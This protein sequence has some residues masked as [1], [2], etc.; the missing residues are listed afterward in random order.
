MQPHEATAGWIGAGVLRLAR[1]AALRDAACDGSLDAEAFGSEVLRHDPPVQNTRRTLAADVTIADCALRAGDSV[2]VVL[3]SAERDPR[4]HAEPDRFRL[5]RPR[6]PSL[7]L[8]AGPHR[9]P[10]GALALR[11][12][13]AAWRALV[14]GTRSDAFAALADRVCWRPSANVRMPVFGVAPRHVRIVS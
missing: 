3:A 12:A 4:R 5:D 2:L 10:G 7:D 8:G 9:C 11:I 14:E 1:D 6:P 13:C